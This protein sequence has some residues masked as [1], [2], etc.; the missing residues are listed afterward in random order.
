MPATVQSAAVQI[1]LEASR[2]P[3]CTME[4]PFVRIDSFSARPRKVVAPYHCR[5][6]ARMQGWRVEYLVTV[7]NL[8]LGHLTVS[9]IK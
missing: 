8:L 2:R 4:N 5:T 6:S 7:G 3:E 9:N 1:E